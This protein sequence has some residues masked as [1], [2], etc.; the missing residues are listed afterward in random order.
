MDL[1]NG[2][3]NLTKNMSE[4]YASGSLS[5]VTLVV[6]GTKFKAHKMILAGQSPYF[7]ALFY[8]NL[9]E[10]TQKEIELKEISVKAFEAVLKYLYGVPLSLG[11]Y[12]KDE[13]V[14]NI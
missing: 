4:L 13:E 11:D 7:K 8:G 1:L 9:K 12:M 14:T 6:D 3:S 2:S 10:A 5:D